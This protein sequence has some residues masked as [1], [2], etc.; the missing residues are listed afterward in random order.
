MKIGPIL[1]GVKD[2]TNFENWSNLGEVGFKVGRIMK[3]GPI[4]NGVKDWTNFEN[5]SNLGINK[6]R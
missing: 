5:W 4:L 2:W 6:R 3:I 1:N